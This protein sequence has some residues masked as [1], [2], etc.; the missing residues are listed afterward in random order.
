MKKLIAVLIVLVLSLGM[1]AGC[2]EHPP[3]P[4]SE[5]LELFEEYARTENKNTGDKIMRRFIE[6]PALVLEALTITDYSESALI[7]IGSSIAAN[8][9]AYAEAMAILD[10]LELDEDAARTLGYIHANINYWANH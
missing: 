5:I 7:L 6:E 4:I 1:F 2:T 3:E 9:E 10:S 8:P